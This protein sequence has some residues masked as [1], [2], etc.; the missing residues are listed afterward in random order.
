MWYQEKTE[1]DQEY[2]DAY[3]K[4]GTL[5]KA[6]AFCGVC[7]DTIRYALLRANI[8]RT[9]WQ[10]SEK[11]EREKKVSDEELVKASEKMT[12]QEIANKY[13]MNVANVD[14][15]LKRLNVCAVKAAHSTFPKRSDDQMLDFVNSK[16]NHE[17]TFVKRIGA[18][19]AELRCNACGYKTVRGLQTIRRGT[20]VCETC[21]KEKA[22]KNTE[23]VSWTAKKCVYCGQ[24]FITMHSEALYCSKICK[25]KAKGKSS[26]YS[27]RARHY[28]VLYDNTITLKKVIKRDKNI[29]QICGT[30]C[31]ENDK[32]WGSNGPLYPSID[33]I[34]ALANGGNHTWD[35]VQLAHCICNSIKRDLV[36][37]KEA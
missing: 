15:R 33:H 21:K 24:D 10:H 14:K 2:I 7:D 36:Y 3:L 29:C 17:F 16:L 27:A 35:N 19:K 25:R 26:Q 31:N 32:T 8:K 12:R 6:G 18:N 37:A 22:R 5:K 30:P 20:V 1:R 28:G 4:L 11:N 9:G 23:Q 13:Q 34:T